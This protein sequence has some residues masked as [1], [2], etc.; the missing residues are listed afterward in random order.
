MDYQAKYV[1]SLEQEIVRLRDENDALKSELFKRHGFGPQP[2]AP[3]D[4]EPIRTAPT[5]TSVKH[6]MESRRMK[7]AREKREKKEGEEQVQ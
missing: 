5:W 3:Q 4:L 1:E 2:E 6:A 7:E